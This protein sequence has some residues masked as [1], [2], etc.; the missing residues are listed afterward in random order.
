MKTIYKLD[1]ELKLVWGTAYIIPG[2]FCD[3][4]ACIFLGIFGESARTRGVLDV[5]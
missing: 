1:M 2:M 5:E 4:R 3:H